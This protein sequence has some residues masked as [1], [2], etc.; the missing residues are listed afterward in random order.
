MN[1]I[2][3]YKA[4]MKLGITIPEYCLLDVVYQIQSV[5]KYGFCGLSVKELS[6]ITGISQRTIHR[7]LKSFEQQNIVKREGECR[8]YLTNI[9]DNKFIK[10]KTAK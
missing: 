6:K 4:A 1:S 7:Y 9:N 3:N 5:S 8:I 10:Y 2:V